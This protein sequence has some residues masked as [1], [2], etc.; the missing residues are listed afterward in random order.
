MENGSEHRKI[1][2]SPVGTKHFRPVNINLKPHGLD[3]KC[4]VIY[5]FRALRYPCQ[6][7]VLASWITL[8]SQHLTSLPPDFGTL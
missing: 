7:K 8:K 2:I 4:N 6:Q 1:A 3:D 5:M